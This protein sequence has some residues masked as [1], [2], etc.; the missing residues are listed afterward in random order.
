MKTKIL[1]SAM[2]ASVLCAGSAPSMGGALFV[3]GRSSC[4]T[5]NCGTQK[6][7]G[8]YEISQPWV[9]QIY[10]QANE[11][12]R[13]VVVAQTHD[14]EMGVFSPDIEE[15]HWVN[16]DGGGSLRPLIKVDPTP[17][18]GYYVVALSHVVGSA[19]KGTFKLLYGRYPSGNPNCTNPTPVGLNPRLRNRVPDEGKLGATR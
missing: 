4:T 8:R 19:V 14:L 16:D 18:A 3:D 9:G 10:A 15:N 17:V 7:F 6:I 12:L 13:L 1:L 2:I 11:C 5:E